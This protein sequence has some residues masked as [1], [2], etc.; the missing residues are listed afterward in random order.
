MEALTIQEEVMIRRRFLGGMPLLL[1]F[2]AKAQPK[3][4]PG[5]W[6]WQA[7]SDYD[8]TTNEART[9]GVSFYFRVADPAILAIRATASVAAAET[10]PESPVVSIHETKVTIVEWPVKGAA[11][12]AAG[13][14]FPILSYAGIPVKYTIPSILIELIRA[15]GI[16]TYKA[17]N[18]M[19]MGRQDL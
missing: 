4:S 17:E 12:T 10:G 9:M 14:Y 1:P 3:A 8:P 11:D 19:L 15:D 18:P 16:T 2:A 7:G 6:Y 5:S 13:L